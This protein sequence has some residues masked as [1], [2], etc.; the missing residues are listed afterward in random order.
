MIS[1][2]AAAI[3]YAAIVMFSNMPPHR[4]VMATGPEGGTYYEVGQRYRAALARE[5]V[6]VQLVPTQGSIES[7]AMLHDPHSGVSVALIQGGEHWCGTEIRSRI[8]RDALL[9]AYVVVS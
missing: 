1:V 2:T 6:D 4:I 5:N 8:A 7:L 3:G 9:R